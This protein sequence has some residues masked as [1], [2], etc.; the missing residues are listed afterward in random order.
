MKKYSE[1]NVFRR[2]LTQFF[3][4]SLGKSTH[5]LSEIKKI[6]DFSQIKRIL[7]VRPNHRL[8]NTLLITP[9]VEEVI[10]VFPN[11]SIDLFVKGGVATTVFQHYNQVKNYIILP[12]KHFKELFQYIKGWFVL[13]TKK[14]DLVINVSSGSSSGKLATKLSRATYKFY[15]TEFEKLIKFNREQRHFAKFPVYKFR[16][17]V[18][19]YSYKITELPI[20]QL[21]LHLSDVELKKGKQ[22]LDAVVPF[23]EKETIAIFTFATGDKCYS[24]EWWLTFYNKLVANF[25]NY[26]IIE[27]LPVENVSQIDFIPPTFYSKEIR[28]IAA[29]IANTK[30]FIGADSGMMHLACTT[31]TAV[32][33]L[34]SVTDKDKYGP[35]GHL[36]SGINT[37]KTTIDQCLKKVENI[38]VS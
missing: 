12:K 34:F 16:N 17:Y 4:S 3:T 27:I 6:K 36:K 23:P 11:A 30:L 10:Q 7:I 2:K 19:D 29:F 31:K 37:N 21:N 35:Y 8:G 14:Y 13:G 9:L 38:L 26:N 22:M 20:K 33:G 15:G 28:D 24:K 25:P 5:S 1:I 18:Y 32:I